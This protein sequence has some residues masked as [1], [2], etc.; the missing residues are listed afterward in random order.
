MDDLHPNCVRINAI[1][2]EAG[3]P[4]RVRILPEAAPT[5]VAAA[6]QIGCSVGAIANSL[7]FASAEN[8]PILVLASGAHRVNTTAVASY[9]GTATLKRA[10]PEFVRAATGQVIGGVAPI[11]H[12]A[13]L[14][15]LLDVDLAQYDE[16]WAAGGIA[17]AVFAIEYGQLLKLT[18]AEA[19]EIS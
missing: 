19:I 9:L 5:A 18:A 17:H 13:P 4:G 7:V 8:E 11:G 6:E 14:R 12:P 1:L 15:T 16:V 10:T 2:A 3:L